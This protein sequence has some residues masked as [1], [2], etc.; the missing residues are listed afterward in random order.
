VSVTTLEGG[1]TG[2]GGLPL[3]WRGH[4]AAAPRAA[5]VV[6]HGLGDHAGRYD[7]FAAR[8]AGLGISTWAMDL[9]G[10]GRSGGR[11]GHVPEFGVYLQELD[12][13]RREVERLAT[14]AVPLFLLGHSMGGL[15]AI[16]YM[17]EYSGAFRG[18]VICSPWLATAMP[19]PRWKALLAPL[20]SRLLPTL[21][22]RHGVRPEDLSR[23]PAVVEAHRQDPLVQPI[24]TPRTFAEASRAM[25]RALQ[26]SDRFTAPLLFMVG[27]TDRVVNADR[28]LHFARTTSSADLTVRVLPGA[29][30]ELLLEL[31]AHATHRQVGEWIRARA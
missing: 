16:R 31:D 26:R 14:P 12:L 30:H 4:A 17:E 1:I 20:L 18:A 27:D 22:F 8:M 3:V 7:D 2:V 15:I 24:I 10:H 11:R 29:F 23:D 9:R 28:A 13:F 6:V 21:P 25:G 19:V 5:L